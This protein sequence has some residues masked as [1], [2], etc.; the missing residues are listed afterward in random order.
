MADKHFV[1]ELLRFNLNLTFVDKDTLVIDDA[2]DV[3]SF[4]PVA[5]VVGLGQLATATPAK[6]KPGDGHAPY[7]GWQARSAA[8]APAA[9]AEGSD[10]GAL[11][12]GL[13]RLFESQRMQ[14]GFADLSM[15]EQVDAVSEAADES[16]LD[17]ISVSEGFSIRGR[18]LGLA[19]SG[20]SLSV[21]ASGLIVPPAL[22]AKGAEGALQDSPR[23]LRW[24]LPGVDRV[25]G[26]RFG[27]NKGLV[28]ELGHAPLASHAQQ[29]WLAGAPHLHAHTHMA[30]TDTIHGHT[31]RQQRAGAPRGAGLYDQSTMRGSEQAPFSVTSFFVMPKSPRMVPAVDQARRSG[32]EGGEDACAFAEEWR[33]GGESRAA[34][35]DAAASVAV[36][37]VLDDRAGVDSGGKAGSLSILGYDADGDTDREKG[38]EAESISSQHEHIS[39]PPLPSWGGMRSSVGAGLRHT[40]AMRRT[41]ALADDRTAA[42]E[43]VELEQEG[44]GLPLVSDSDGGGSRWEWQSVAGGETPSAGSPVPESLP[45]RG[46][47][48]TR[49][50]ASVPSS[51]KDG[52]VG[53]RDGSEALSPSVRAQM[54]TSVDGLSMTFDVSEMATDTE[55]VASRACGTESE[56]GRSNFVLPVKHGSLP[57]P[58]PR[59]AVSA[60]V[61]HVHAW[62]SESART[63]PDSPKDLHRGGA[64]ELWTGHFAA[65]EAVA[66]VSEDALCKPSFFRHGGSSRES[67]AVT[68]LGLR[69]AGQGGGWGQQRSGSTDSAAE[70]KG[71]GRSDVGWEQVCER[72][73]LAVKSRRDSMHMAQQ[74]RAGTRSGVAE[75]SNITP[76]L[77][78]L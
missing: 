75:E 38:A 49:A 46:S 26:T 45:S 3:T 30:Q 28:D 6:R 34:A 62:L 39:V 54:S 33:G 7:S 77:L 24:P 15:A 31:P 52:D 76:S 12:L 47:A 44:S 60:R 66:G 57:A 11:S 48:W 61:S 19:S 73:R 51:R 32:A 41:E 21:A 71:D 65:D 42:V 36:V 63:P 1:E 59:K 2:D 53:T 70:C 69:S 14:T 67:P 22:A 13:G 56:L 8:A 4:S 18:A 43:R 74:P 40:N 64:A 23:C 68:S 29:H 27:G 10:G 37:H 50:A 72:A 35:F 9:G 25:T 58:R 55:T 20:S 78:P 5:S 17:D 16:D